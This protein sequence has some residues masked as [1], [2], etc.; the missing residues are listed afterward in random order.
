MP[1]RTSGSSSTIR[2]FLLPIFHHPRG[3]FL[4]HKVLNFSS[5]LLQKASHGFTGV[6]FDGL[7]WPVRSRTGQACLL[8]GFAIVQLFADA[9]SDGFTANAVGKSHD[10][11]EFRRS[12]DRKSV[13]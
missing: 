1:W 8:K 7:K 2:I 9:L 5:H 6:S 11:E 12:G 4:V 10:E 13:V 3:D